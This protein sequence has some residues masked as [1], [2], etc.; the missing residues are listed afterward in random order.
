M[1]VVQYSA[2]CGS[3]TQLYYVGLMIHSLTITRNFKIA[4]K[5]SNKVFITSVLF[6][7]KDITIEA[8]SLTTI[9]KNVFDFQ[10]DF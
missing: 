3:Y 9:V 10:L 4:Y 2:Q 6:R 1:Q 8:A 5:S 7:V